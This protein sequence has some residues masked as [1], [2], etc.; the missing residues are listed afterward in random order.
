MRS[1]NLVVEGACLG[2]V[3][4]SQLFRRRWS[5]AQDMITYHTNWVYPNSYSFIF[6]ERAHIIIYE[7]LGVSSDFRFRKPDPRCTGSKS[8]KNFVARE[9][10]AS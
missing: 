3:W 4:I 2:E 7:L 8:P 9:L 6:H 10:P 1:A 5:Q